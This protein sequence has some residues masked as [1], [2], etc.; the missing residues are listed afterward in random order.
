M[1]SEQ[2]NRTRFILETN[3]IYKK[4]LFNIGIFLLLLFSCSLE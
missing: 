1:H 4:R 2:Q 3:A